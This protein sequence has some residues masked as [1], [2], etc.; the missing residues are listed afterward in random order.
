[1]SQA[2]TDMAKACDYCGQTGALKGRA[3]AGKQV[4]LF[5]HT[6]E[7]SCFNACR[8]RYFEP[9]YCSRT[10]D[11]RLDEEHER[12]YLTRRNPA[13]RLHIA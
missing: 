4:R 13:C 11:K 6:V 2:K 8:G 3:T 12:W 7:R 9:C 1:M 5:C 10:Y